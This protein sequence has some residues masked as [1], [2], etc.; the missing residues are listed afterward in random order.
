MPRS[1]RGGMG[2]PALHLT[3]NSFTM[4]PAN[5]VGKKKPPGYVSDEPTSPEVTCMGRVRR[6]KH[7]KA[8]DALLLDTE[9]TNKLNNIGTTYNNTIIGSGTKLRSRSRGSTPRS[10]IPMSGT[11]VLVPRPLAQ[12]AMYN[13]WK[14][15][16][17]NM[18]N[19]IKIHMPNLTKRL[20]KL[21]K[22][23]GA[24]AVDEFML[25]DLLRRRALISSALKDVT[26]PKP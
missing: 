17:A 13:R 12:P 23:S 6:N 1:H 24:K 18:A 19:D 8:W 21:H 26:R 3:A 7:C 16:W 15:F 20:K 2:A 25:V 5:V 4:M 10:S 11:N 9:M 14:N 22:D